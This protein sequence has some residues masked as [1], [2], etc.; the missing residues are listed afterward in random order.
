M[1]PIL[2][3][4]N[5]LYQSAA[6]KPPSS[7]KNVRIFGFGGATDWKIQGEPRN[8]PSLKKTRNGVVPVAPPSKARHLPFWQRVP[9]C[10]AIASNSMKFG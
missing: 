5:M 1:A 10:A 4:G 9:P 7:S 6:G 8:T 3:V 2:G